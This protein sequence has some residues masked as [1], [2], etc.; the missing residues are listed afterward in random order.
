MSKLKIVRSLFPVF[1][2]AGLVVSV[3]AQQPAATLTMKQ[4]K[5]NVWVGLGGSGGNSTII[6]G[7]TGVIVVDAKQTE[8]GAKDLLAEIA[9]I[10]PKPVKT[11]ILTHSDGDHVNGLVAYPTG[12]EIIAHENNKKELQAALDSGARGAPPKDRLPTRVTTKE[13]E[14]TTIDGVKLELYHFAPAHTS[15]DLMVYLPNEKIVSTGDIVVTNRADDNPNVHFEKNGKTDGWLTTVKGLIKLNADTYV[16]GH[17]DLVTKADLQRKFDATTARRN[18]IAAMIKEGKTL[19]QI[20]VALPDP[21]APGAAAAAPRGP[22]PAPPA[23]AP[24]GAA[25]AP[26][27]GGTPAKTFVETAYGELAKK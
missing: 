20:K 10:T 12:I 8:A 26:R 11:V 16:T 13:K 25:A 22:A 23:G 24:A 2:M 19:D 7:Q 5:P 3:M 17:G 6:I 18:K 4:L 9:K 1:A 15:G 27:G 21:P 14:A